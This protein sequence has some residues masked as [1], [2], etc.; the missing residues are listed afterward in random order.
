MNKLPIPKSL[1]EDIK[2]DGLL[3]KPKELKGE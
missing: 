2:R 1:Y 3:D